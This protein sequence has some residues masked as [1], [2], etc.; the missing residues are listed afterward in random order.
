MSIDRKQFNSEEY[1]L[2]RDWIKNKREQGW[3]WNRILD[4][5]DNF[6]YV[7]NEDNDWPLFTKEEWKELVNLQKEDEDQ[8]LTIAFAGANLSDGLE[9]NNVEVPAYTSYSDTAWSVYVDK[10]KENGFSIDTIN[11]IREQTLKIA[12][13]MSVTNSVGA[14]ARK[15]LV[16]GNVQSGKTANMEALMALCAD[17]GWNM[18][19]I[20]SGTIE[21]LRQQTSKR[22]YNDLCSGNYS[23]WKV[24]NNTKPSAIRLNDLPS[25]HAILFYRLFCFSCHSH[26]PHSSIHDIT[27]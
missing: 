4:K 25:N 13:Q 11:Q 3:E 27:V 21:N 20:L 6:F 16:I 23:K 19:I 26:F 22:I 1:L 15:G 12:R 14:Q 8:R 24:W 10:L 2:P 18:F 5:N 9:N 7:Q 17:N